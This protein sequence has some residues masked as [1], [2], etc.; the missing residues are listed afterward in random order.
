[1]HRSMIAGVFAVAAL[2]LAGCSGTGN[3]D[4]QQTE[5]FRV[6]LEGEP[7]TVVVSEDDSEAK[8][9][10][11]ATCADP[12]KSQSTEPKQVNV[13]VLV[14]PAHADACVVKVVIKD[15]DTGEILDE[16]EVDTGGS[17]STGTVTQTQTGT[18]TVTQTGTQTVTQTQSASSG[19][20]VT[21]NFFVTVKGNHNIVVLTQAIQGTAN[22]DV[23]ASHA[24][25]QGVADSGDDGSTSTVSASATG[26]NATGTT[27]T[28]STY[29]G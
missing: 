27:S 2:A 20:S 7:Q 26:T 6:Q 8:Q 3:F 11:V 12:C 17:G 9:V 21:Q 28:T 16:R 23:S 15:Q 29:T 19:Q 1:M 18:Q 13:K 14:T 5:P 24:S 25:G 10:V 4:V 22:V